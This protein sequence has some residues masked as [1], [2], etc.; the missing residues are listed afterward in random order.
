VP[1]KDHH[2]LVD[3]DEALKAA[4]EAHIK[5]LFEPKPLDFSVHPA[6]DGIELDGEIVWPA[7]VFTELERDPLDP[8]SL[9]VPSF[10]DG[11]FRCVWTCGVT[12]HTVGPPT[13]TCVDDPLSPQ[14]AWT[15]FGTPPGTP[16]HI[17]YSWAAASGFIRNAVVSSPSHIQVR[18]FISRRV[19]DQHLPDPLV[20]KP[21]EDNNGLKHGLT[22]QLVA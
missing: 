5:K 12:Y 17:G 2:P 16:G 21:Y 15:G 9:I 1:D 6:L 19:P 10:P 22:A 7:P 20:V 18:A 14:V 8:T 13:G 3:P 4:F 11:T